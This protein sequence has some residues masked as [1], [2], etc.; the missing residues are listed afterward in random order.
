MNR[1]PVRA[2]HVRW[3][4][5]GDGFVLY[6]SVSDSYFQANEVGA[7]IWELLDG[8]LDEQQVAEA[9]AKEFSVDVA[10]ANADVA[11]YVS[12]LLKAGLLEM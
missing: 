11:E 6:N 1:K 4:P 3:A 12:E 10:T 2:K 8:S 5:V 7:S 9:I